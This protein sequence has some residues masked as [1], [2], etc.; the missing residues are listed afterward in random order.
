MDKQMVWVDV[1]RCTGCGACIEVCPAGAVVLVGN[2]AH[3]DEEACTGCRTCMDACPEGAMQPVIRGELVPASQRPVPAAYRPSPLVETAGA[4]VAVAGVGLLVKMA[5]ALARAV[6]RWLTR[7]SVVT[8]TPRSGPSS[9]GGT[10][11]AGRR[12]RHRRRGGQG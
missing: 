1:V 11:D 12:T 3:V 6:G 2:K 9:V 4:A 5:G 7:W 10:A 8:R